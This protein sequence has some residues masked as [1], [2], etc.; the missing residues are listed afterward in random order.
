MRRLRHR[1][2]N[3]WAESPRLYL[4]AARRRHP[5]PSP[6]VIGPHTRVVIDGYTRSAT[7]FAVYS[8]QLSQPQPVRMAHHLHAPAQLIEASRRGVPAIA[9]IRNP[10]DT[11]VSQVVR[12]PG[13]TIVDALVAYRRF[14][15]C[16]MPYRDH[17]V[18]GEFD[19]VTADLG[20]VVQRLNALTASAFSEFVPTEANLAEVLELSGQRSTEIPEWFHTLLRFES[21]LIGREELE[22]VR[23]RLPLREHEDRLD[24]WVPSPRRRQTTELLLTRWEEPHLA[25]ERRRAW[26]AYERFVT[27]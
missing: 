14:Y 9:L 26:A 27:G 13:V 11:V 2:R 23:A 21:G 18:V 24:A 7:T 16:L 6:E 5:G 25:K 4:P 10:R 20:A 8:F 15:T 17:L 3:R 1:V 19:E 12:E 22:A